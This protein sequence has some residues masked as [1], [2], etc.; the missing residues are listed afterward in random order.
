M[1]ALAIKL[2]ALITMFVDHFFASCANY[3]GTD[4]FG[5]SRIPVYMAGTNL[6]WV[7]RMVGRIAF[8]I[9]CF[10]IVEGV[11]HTKNWKKY[12][13]RLGA[14]VLLSEIPF[15][16]ALNGLQIADWSSQNVYFT[17]LFGMLIVTF[18][19]EVRSPWKYLAWPVLTG[20]LG[21]AAKWYLHT[22]YDWSGVA[23]IAVMGLMYEPWE[24][25]FKPYTPAVQQMLR[26]V[27]CALGIGVLYYKNQFE[28]YAFFALLPI[29]L[30][31]G[32]KG[33]SNKA[34]QYGSY[35]FYPVHLL[36]LAAAVYFLG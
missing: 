12:M 7:A 34:I 24:K 27:F 9:F 11:Y 19:K 33:Y 25:V 8:P 5:I 36:G 30:Y 16:L 10:Q 26:V 29:A 20:V 35:L 22:D 23:C 31:N 4:L 2:L 21:Y 1:N 18:M 15:D 13:L 28:I 3:H 32:R 6:Y 17:L 14:L